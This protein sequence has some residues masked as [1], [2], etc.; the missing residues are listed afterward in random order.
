MTLF[1]CLTSIKSDANEILGT[2]DRSQDNT[3]IDAR[4]ADLDHR[5]RNLVRK[6][7]EYVEAMG[8]CKTLEVERNDAPLINLH[9]LEKAA[10]RVGLHRP[11]AWMDAVELVEPCIAHYLQRLLAK[12]DHSKA[13]DLCAWYARIFPSCPDIQR[14]IKILSEL[15]EK[16]AIVRK[17]LDRARASVGMSNL[18]TLPSRF[19]YSRDVYLHDTKGTYVVSHGHNLHEY[20]ADWKPL[21]NFGPLKATSGPFAPSL[22]ARGNKLYCAG[23]LSPEA[24]ILDKTSGD[25][26][27]HLEF[28]F[29]VGSIKPFKDGFVAMTG[30]DESFN[31]RRITLFTERLQVRKSFDIPLSTS[32]QLCAVCEYEGYIAVFPATVNNPRVLLVSPDTGEIRKTI[33]LPIGCTT[34]YCASREDHLTWIT[35]MDGVMAFNNDWKLE[36]IKVFPSSVSY[37]VRVI[38]TG[39]TKDYFLTGH[40]EKL[41]HWC[42][43]PGQQ[44]P[45]K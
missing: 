14:A 27:E 25:I 38:D 45:G 31:T 21:G 17:N 24:W 4:L 34:I 40:N 8:F 26:L 2:I 42:S 5:F 9:V 16:D 37:D 30:E 29:H 1:Y 33:S 35:T 32:D 22:N 10:P 11:L 13:T 3:S 39:D 12:R 7:V 41:W 19:A 20:T 6:S 15:K 18:Q 36:C 28:D 44:S 23:N 43:M